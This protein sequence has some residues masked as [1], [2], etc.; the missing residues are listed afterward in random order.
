[1]QYGEYEW[2]DDKNDINI[3]KHKIDFYT[4]IKA[5]ED[6][7]ALYIE[8]DEHSVEEQRYI[9]IGWVNKVLFVVYTYRGE[10]TRIISARLAD[11]YERRLYYGDFN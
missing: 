9:V 11:S 1:M 3:Q 10:R 8:D 6:P 2:D 5:F 4:A 7:D